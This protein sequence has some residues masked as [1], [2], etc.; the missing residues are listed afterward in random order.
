MSGG[1]SEVVPRL[2]IPNRTVK[3]LSADDSADTCVKVGHRQT[4]DTEAQLTRAGLCA[5]QLCFALADSHRE[6]RHVE[7]KPPPRGQAAC[8]LRPAPVASLVSARGGSV[9]LL[10]QPAANVG[11]MTS[12]GQT[13]KSPR[14]RALA[15]LSK[16]K[17]SVWL[18]CCCAPPAKAALLRPTLAATWWSQPIPD[19]NP[20][21]PPP[22]AGLRPAPG[23]ACGLCRATVID[24]RCCG[25]PWLAFVLDVTA[26]CRQYR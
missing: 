25:Q 5:L 2:P 11:R 22:P 21:S 24:C 16:H 19:N 20:R 18:G 9:V 14:K 26:G 10:V 8:C 4:P 1:H 6:D 3:R 17:K 23:C 7:A 15:C 12:T 13:S